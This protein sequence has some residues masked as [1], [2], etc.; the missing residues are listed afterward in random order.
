MVHMGLFYKDSRFFQWFFRSQKSGLSAKSFEVNL[1]VTL[2]IVNVVVKQDKLWT[3]MDISNTNQWKSRIIEAK[4]RGRSFDI[5]VKF[6][7]KPQVL[8]VLD[9]VEQ[10]VTQDECPSKEQV[11]DELEGAHEATADEDEEVD[12]ER[13]VAKDLA[14]EG[15]RILWIVE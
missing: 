12:Q 6:I 8:A 5:V 11:Q 13:V 1:D 2:L 3:V 4:G 7:Q 9:D 10:H 14:Y 15:E